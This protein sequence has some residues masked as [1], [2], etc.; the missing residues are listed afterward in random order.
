MNQDPFLETLQQK[1]QEQAALSQTSPLPE[2]VKP[3]A[4]AVGLHY[5]QFLLILS[6]AVAVIVS[7]LSFSVLYSQVVGV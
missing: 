6:C 5:W 2:W 7:V 4:S 3:F 1:A